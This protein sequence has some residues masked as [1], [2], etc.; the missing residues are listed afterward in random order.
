MSR[1]N[2]RR[3]EKKLIYSSSTISVSCLSAMIPEMTSAL[4]QQQ[5]DIVP[6]ELLKLLS[7]ALFDSYPTPET[8]AT[9]AEYAISPAVD[10]VITGLTDM[11]S[12]SPSQY[13]SKLL[14]AETR[15]GLCTWLGDE[16]RVSSSTLGGLLDNLYCS[17]IDSL[18]RAII[19]GIISATGQ[20]LDDYID[21]IAPRLSRAI[22]NEVLKQFQR[23]WRTCFEG[24]A[25]ELSEG[26]KAFLL[27]VTS[28]VPG[29]I[30]VEGLEEGEWL[31]QEESERKYPNSLELA[32]R[33][34][35]SQP[36]SAP[37]E[38]PMLQAEQPDTG[39]PV[40]DGAS[41]PVPT[42]A[43]EAD[44][45]ASAPEISMEERSAVLPA[46]D[47]TPD[48]PLPADAPISPSPNMS[49]ADSERV[50]EQIRA[51]DV[52]GPS[53]MVG[54]RRKRGRPSRK[55]ALGP[56]QSAPE[57][58]KRAKVVTG[59]SAVDT[60]VIPST[61]DV[62]ED[63]DTEEDEVEVSGSATKAGPSIFNRLLHKATSLGFFSPSRTTARPDIEIIPATTSASR[64]S[65]KRTRGAV[66][67]TNAPESTSPTSSGKKR[68]TTTNEANSGKQA[69]R[70]RSAASTPS[71]SSSRSSSEVIEISDDD[72]EDELILSPETARKRR[73]EEAADGDLMR[74][75]LLRASPTRARPQPKAEQPSL[76]QGRFDDAPDDHTP[77]NTLRARP[78]PAAG[79]STGAIPNPSPARTNQQARVLSMVEEAARA[80]AVVESL[81]FEG[82]MRL[83]KHVNELRDAATT[84]LQERAV[85]ERGAR[86]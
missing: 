36:I 8:L 54:P 17:L 64:S 57:I 50:D 55:R 75:S 20:T 45:S 42:A 41:Q 43:Y 35:G 62:D 84:N 29:L 68:K 85:R 2:Y 24:V 25:L 10:S 12:S 40:A 48:E 5:T 65:R 58:S 7:D 4:V 78:V 72:D 22:S 9:G 86:R 21:L 16:F 15:A 53:A 38:K 6:L 26:V 44:V 27:D 23:F 82:V 14:D 51:D 47:A 39:S 77:Q 73:E 60:T 33:S 80:K 67:D 13:I 28:A 1:L 81:D 69:T 18:S 3:E 59:V 83:L 32:N 71:S 52:F 49:E 74:R 34:S 76:T 63:G 19:S 61:Q 30:K 66:A 46:V 31:E 56:S 11:F 79:P 37:I 70:P